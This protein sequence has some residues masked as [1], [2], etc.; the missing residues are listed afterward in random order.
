MWLKFNQSV[1]LLLLKGL[2]LIRCFKRHFYFYC[3]CGQQHFP[4]KICDF[5]HINIFTSEH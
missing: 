5:S 3:L 4:K 1:L 2:L